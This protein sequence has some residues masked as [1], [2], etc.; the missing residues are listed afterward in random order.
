MVNSFIAGVAMAWFLLARAFIVAAV[1]Y[2]AALL[3]PL[4]FGIGVNVVFGF[5]LAGLV[6]VFER[7]L[8]ESPPSRLLGALI[9]GGVGLALAR[10][11]EAGLFWANTG[12]KRVEFLH[13]FLLI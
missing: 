8:R 13:S 7:R 3:R 5:V 12:D 6:V 11:I 9:G 2:S 10:G 4:S 1:A